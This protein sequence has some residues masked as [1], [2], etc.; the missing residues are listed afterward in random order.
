MNILHILVAI[1]ICL[2]L[3]FF[4]ILNSNIG[5]KYRIALLSILIFIS[6]LLYTAD[7]EWRPM[8]RVEAIYPCD[9][10]SPDYIENVGV[11]MSYLKQP[12]DS[13]RFEFDPMMAQCGD[14]LRSYLL[15]KQ[16]KSGS[17][18]EDRTMLIIAQEPIPQYEGELFVPW[19]Y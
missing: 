17:I 18:Y 13:I 12:A 9:E 3:Y 5:I 8:H 16:T 14:T 10:T 4:F 19:L 7:V 15:L 2:L 6:F 1:L 11:V